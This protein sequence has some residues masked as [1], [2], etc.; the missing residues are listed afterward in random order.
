MLAR[1]PSRWVTWY[2]PKPSCSPS[3]KSSLAGRPIA[4]AASRNAWH[5]T[6][7]AR[8][9]LTGSGPPAPWNSLAPRSLSSARLK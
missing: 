9:S 2:Q 5:M 7:R 3:L 1:R 6:L 8:A 4:S